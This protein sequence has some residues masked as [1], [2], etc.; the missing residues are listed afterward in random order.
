M[1]FGKGAEPNCLVACTPRLG[2]A[3]MQMCDNEQRHA[4]FFKY[5]FVYRKK[6]H[7]LCYNNLYSAHHHLLHSQHTFQGLYFNVTRARVGV[8][9]HVRV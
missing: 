9:M 8:N 7:L 6:T 1:K 4:C 5:N 2:H 3:Y